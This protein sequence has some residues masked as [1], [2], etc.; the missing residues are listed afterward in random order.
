MDE[1]AAAVAAARQDP[2]LISLRSRI[3]ESVKQVVEAW[4]GD[5]EVAD[6]SCVVFVN[7]V[8]TSGHLFVGAKLDTVFVRDTHFHFPST[9]LIT[10]HDSGRAIIFGTM[11]VS[12]CYPRSEDKFPS[13]VLDH[14]EGKDRRGGSDTS[15]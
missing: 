15:G 9:P 13:V 8:L 6:V 3:E 12:R 7:P 5:G 4:N 11:A 2:R 1:K 10:G 14:E